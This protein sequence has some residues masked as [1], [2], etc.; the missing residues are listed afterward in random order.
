MTSSRTTTDRLWSE[1]ALFD[2]LEGAAPTAR[3]WALERLTE[4]GTRL[5]ADRLIGL[6][7]DADREISLAAIQHARRLKVVECAPALTALWT[8]AADPTVR[9]NALG[10]LGE[11]DRESAIELA[12][13]RAGTPLHPSETSFVQVLTLRAVADDRPGLPEVLLDAAA[14]PGSIPSSHAIEAIAGP[15]GDPFHPLLL[16]GDDVEIPDEARGLDAAAL[17]GRI[18]CW[19]K[20][21]AASLASP[22]ARFLA[23]RAVETALRIER[24][25]RALK[26]RGAFR[27]WWPAAFNAATHVALGC[28]DYAES[29]RQSRTA[30]DRIEVLVCPWAILPDAQADS[31]IADADLPALIEF[32]GDGELESEGERINVARVL[33]RRGGPEGRIMAARLGTLDWEDYPIPTA[34]ALDGLARGFDRVEIDEKISALYLF[35]ALDHPAAL[36]LADEHYES[37]LRSDEHAEFVG[38]LAKLARPELFDRL[39]AEWAPGEPAMADALVTIAEVNGRPVPDAWRAEARELDAM[40][41]GNFDRDAVTASLRCEECGRSYRYDFE[42]VIV[43]GPAS[44]DTP[45]R[46]PRIVVCKKCGALDRWTMTPRVRTAVLMQAFMDRDRRMRGGKLFIKALGRPREFS[47]LGDAIRACETELVRRGND[48]DLLV[49]IG[50]LYRHGGLSD[51]AVPFYERALAVAPRHSDAGVGLNLAREGRTDFD[52]ASLDPEVRESPPG[53]PSR[54][55]GRNEPCPCGSGLKY[56]RCCIGAG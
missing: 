51:R 9:A 53:P 18:E 27:E 30:V 31:L 37:F 10:A 19:R 21:S 13:S 11:I 15:G 24:V 16:N 49:A 29:A 54:K 39:A 23:D 44:H 52:L 1:T 48:A 35:L 22:A 3:A 2:R 7:D 36:R 28:R 5:Q 40:L 14:G 33:A 12:A 46:F 34:D 41:R 45:I 38:F 25:E 56:K 42:F 32:A 17:A 47:S 26:G 4:R 43:A 20:E 55:I 50:N 8:S 6:F